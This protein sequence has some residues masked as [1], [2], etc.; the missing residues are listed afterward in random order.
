M[1]IGIM[2]RCIDEKGGIAIYAR[3]I[4]EELLKIDQKNQ[5]VL[6]FPS[7]THFNRYNAFENVTPLLL[8]SKSKVLWD[9]VYVPMA[10]KRERVDVIFNPKFTL[11]LWGRPKAVMTVHGADWFLP[12]YKILYHPVDRLYMRFMMPMYIRRSSAIISASDYSTQGFLTYLP[13]SKGKVKTIHYCANRMFQPMSD[14]AL[15]QGIRQ[16]HGLQDPFI[17]TLIHYDTGRKNFANMLQAFARAKKKGIAHKFVVGGREVQRYAE[18]QPLRELGV[19]GDVIFKGWIE[20]DDLPAL[21]NAADLYLYPTRLEGFPIPVC[22]ALACGC[23]IVTS[24]DGVFREAAEDAAIYV[25]PE[26]PDDI[27]KAICRVLKDDGL[28]QSMK[29]KGL[30]R[31]KDLSWDN[32]AS[33]TL[34]LFNSL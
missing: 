10:A 34:A 3:N 5:Y 7:M 19:E 11:P 30:A 6:F 16:K 21:Y 27:A 22:E 18:E 20:Q 24:K 14:Q 23:P 1:R 29:G 8:E 17:L 32:C 12:E 33:E 13:M 25:D 28:R 15:L 26:N 9:Q 4:V 31:A 2:L